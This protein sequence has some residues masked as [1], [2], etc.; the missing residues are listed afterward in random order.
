MANTTLLTQKVPRHAYFREAGAGILRG[1][2]LF[3]QLLW[4]ELNRDAYQQLFDD[5][6]GNTITTSLVDDR[7]TLKNDTGAVTMAAGKAV[8]ASTASDDKYAGFTGGDLAWKGNRNCMMQVKAAPTA[9]TKSK[10]EIGFTGIVAGNAGCVNAID[11]PTWTAAEDT[12]I[13]CFDTDGSVDVWQAMAYNSAAPKKRVLYTSGT[14]A[15]GTSAEHDTFTDTGAAFVTNS[16]AG[17]RLT[18]TLAGHPVTSAVV[19]SNNATVLTLPAGDTNLRGGWDN[20]I[21]GDESAYVIANAPAALTIPV[22]AQYNTYTI[23]IEGTT[24]LFYI[25]G[26]QVAKIPAAVSAAT[27]GLT[28]WLFAQARGDGAVNAILS[29]DYLWLLQSRSATA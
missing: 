16:L 22:A 1:Q 15:A 29:V 5:F 27:V 26:I 4:A 19:L 23:K 7:Y 11:D 14:A 12:V 24:A 18:C 8:L 17:Q 3:D 10:F 20:G 28:P 13:F 21:P 9:I 2:T 6:D 25:N